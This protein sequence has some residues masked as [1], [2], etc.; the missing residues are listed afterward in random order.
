M[1]DL[2]IITAPFT[3]T[4]GPSL[5][6][7][8]LKACVQREGFSS[9]TWD[10]SADFNFN[11]Q[12]HT[13]YAAITSWMQSPE[14]NLS[15]DE[16][17]WYTNIIAEYA[18][19]IVEIY[20]PGALAVSVLTQNSQRFAEDLCYHVKMLSSDIKIILGGSGLDI[21]LFQHQLRWYEL[22]LSSGLADC[23]VLGEGEYAV[24]EIL[25]N[26]STGIIKVPQLTNQQLNDIP[27]P[28][29]SD[30]DFSLYPETLRSYWSAN[31]DV[32]TESSGH[33]FLITASKGCVKNCNFCDVGKIWDR[34]R[35][36]SGTQVAN[37]MIELHQ[38]YGA[39]Y[40]SFTD[41]LINGG[42]KPFWEL[43][44]ELA[45]Q[46]P[47]TIKYEAQMICRSQRD[48]PEKYFEAMARAGCHRVQIGME[49]GSERVRIHMG[50]GSSSDDVNYT[51]SM[52]I[53]YNIHQSWNIIAGYPTE[54][55]ADWQETIQMIQYW[56][57]R[58][59]GLLKIA[60]INTFLLLDGVPMTQDQKL[61]DH[62]QIESEIINGYSSFAWVSATNPTNTFA[63][64]AQRFIDLCNMC[65]D[66]ES[67]PDQITNLKRKIANTQKQLEWFHNAKHK[68]VFNII[69]N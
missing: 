8:L 16:F 43:N 9:T 56:I 30:Y 68:K 22:M 33:V 66:F 61:I 26:N 34:F 62:F 38:K 64:R 6:P 63:V 55:D 48:M 24:G 25:K 19:K 13:N 14:L 50:K 11:Y 69:Q 18:R 27:V 51:T 49:S 32:R 21:F 37:E 17:F 45:T 3:Y 36:R 12:N 42:L 58:S 29:Y 31:M 46:L 15:A 47:D 57:P 39:T 7:A 54:T 5:G 23:A 52:L 40:F 4:F 53:K 28:D 65:I 1:S 60:P 20:Q 59:D 41:S 10:M 67:D 44:H 2:L 35:Y